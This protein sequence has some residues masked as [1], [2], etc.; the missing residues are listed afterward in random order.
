MPPR[1]PA[2]TS[3]ALPSLVHWRVQRGLTQAELAEQISVRRATI[4]RIESGK[5]AL[6]K[7]AR[8]IATALGVEVADLQRQP[9][10]T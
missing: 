5:P 1:V 2:P 4:A 9:P 10:T 7:T 3:V 6:V 8:A